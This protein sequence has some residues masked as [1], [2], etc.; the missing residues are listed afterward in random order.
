MNVVSA[1]ISQ[2]AFIFESMVG[3]KARKGTDGR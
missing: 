2:K 1:R 3:E